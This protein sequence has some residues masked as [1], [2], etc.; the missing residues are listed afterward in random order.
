MCKIRSSE[1]QEQE[2]IRFTPYLPHTFNKKDEDNIPSSHR[3][4]LKHCVRSPLVLIVT[5]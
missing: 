3:K 2:S 4:L 5:W 1:G